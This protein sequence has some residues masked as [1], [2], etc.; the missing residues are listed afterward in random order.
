LRQIY[1]DSMTTADISNNIEDLKEAAAYILSHNFDSVTKPCFITMIKLLDNVITKPHEPLVRRIKFSN[2]A[3]ATKIGGCQGGVEFLVACGFARQDA[4]A[5][6]TSRLGGNEIPATSTLPPLPLP[7]LILVLEPAREHTERLVAARRLLETH[8]VRDLKCDESEV[9]RFR[10]PPIPPVVLSSDPTMANGTIAATNTVPTAVAFNP[11]QGQRFDAL[12]AAVGTSLGPDA[13]YT[14]PTLAELHRLQTRREQ[15]QQQ[16][17]TQTA[18]TI[19]HR[20]WNVTL[21]GGMA[22]SESNPGAAAAAASVPASSDSSLLA[23]RAQAQHQKRVQRE[24]GG[25]TTAA[26]REVQRLQRQRVYAHV[27][28]S[29]CCPDGTKIAAQFRPDDT[30]GAVVQ[31]L[32]RECFTRATTGT[33]DRDLEFDLYVT[34]PR[35]LLLPHETLTEASLVPAAKVFV[36]WKGWAAEAIKSSDQGCTAAWISA[37]LLPSH[38][39]AQRDAPAFPSVSDLCTRS[40]AAGII[41]VGSIGH[42]CGPRLQTSRQEVEQGRT[43]VATHDGW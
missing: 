9:P 20:Q 24:T 11:Y 30:I 7:S 10:P 19:Q 1:T 31:A 17:S 23:A 34:P 18:Q 8:L 4:S 21:P 6:P 41:V 15:L 12:S 5:V 37:D 3:I 22:P 28:L 26:M 38:N 16:L 2:A 29:M 40:G 42:G 33:N 14:S 13:N 25:F 39:D 32:Q 36:S 35:R 27:L 43:T